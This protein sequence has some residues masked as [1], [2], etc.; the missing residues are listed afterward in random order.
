MQTPFESGLSGWK[1]QGRGTFAVEKHE[2]KAAG[3]ITVAPEDKLEY[4]HFWYEVKGVQAGDAI[5]VG[6]LA[7]TKGDIADGTGPYLALEWLDAK[8]ARLGVEH[9]LISQKT[10]S[11]RWEI[12]SA[13]GK[14]PVG[15]A[16]LRLNLLLHSHGVAWFADP[17]IVRTEREKPWP[18]LGDKMRRVTVD[19]AKAI[20]PRFLGVG[21]HA[22][23]HS[24]DYPPGVM[25][26]VIY[27]R[28]RE[29]RPSFARVNHEQKWGPK[30]LDRMAAHLLE[31]KKTG[32]QIYVATWDPQNCN[33]PDEFAAYARHIADQLEYL[34][35]TKGCDHIKW[36]CVSNELSLDGWGKLRDDLPK[37]RRY[38][39][40]FFAEFQKRKLNVGL[41]ATDASPIIFWP[42]I[43]WAAQNMDSITAVYGGHQYFNDDPL[44]DERF[45]SRWLSRVTQ[46]SEM[47]K[48]KGKPFILG[49]FG[50]KQEA[51]ERGGVYRDRCVYYETPQEP[52]VGI[53]IS[54]AAIA[55]MNG[56]VAALG[57]WTFMDFPDSTRAAGYEN[58]WGLMRCGDGGDYS[59]RAPYYAYGLLT[60][61]F[62]GR[63]R[64]VR[65]RQRR[66]APARRRCKTQRQRRLDN[67]R[68]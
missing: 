12:L 16:S 37:F 33:T 27:R 64:R 47:A 13:S 43:E 40:A 62:R 60:R 56:G 44:D 2:G 31:M 9:S 46:I 55:A 30:H 50:S 61:Y 52:Q 63:F 53:Q 68:R 29:L 59:T 14:A 11:D 1:T 67:R 8:G 21:F 38:H 20:Q 4:Q 35:K 39:E 48:A 49:E 3:R 41:L 51:G 66:P 57:Y 26:N 58:K 45:Y 32:T 10:G 17:F 54:E 15:T 24:F 6:A 28:W 22:F 18:E 36:Y 34:I 5:Q 19:T 25:E 23:Q 7:R 65:R 42:T